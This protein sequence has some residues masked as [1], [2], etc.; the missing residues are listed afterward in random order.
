MRVVDW[1][2]YSLDNCSVAR[3]MQVLGE[4]WTMLV[5]RDAFNGIRR[6]EDFQ[7]RLKVSRP[8]LS[9]RLQTLVNEGVLAR[10]PY[11]Q[12][13][14]R[15]RHEYRLTDKGRDLYPAIVALMQWGDRWLADPEGPPVLLEHRDCGARVTVKL[16]DDKGH[17]LDSI[18]EVSRRPG[19][20]ARPLAS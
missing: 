13:G 6:F 2:D 18:R 16:V 17:V 20:S 7:T 14:D 19:P 3:S 8:L 5:L 4:K 1:M 9:Q 10:V 15:V 12:P 11:Q